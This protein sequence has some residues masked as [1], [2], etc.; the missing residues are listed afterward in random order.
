MLR[1]LHFA[2]LSLSLSCGAVLAAENVPRLDVA[3]T[4]RGAYGA[5]QTDTATGPASANKA[6]NAEARQSTYKS[7]MDSEN[8]ARDSAGKRWARV[9][10]ESRRTCLSM[11][12]AIFPSY[13]ELDA[14][15]QMYDDKDPALSGGTPASNVAPRKR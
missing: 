1:H 3:R 13:V 9:K 6:A 2:A 8:A 15:L 10:G 4:C 14:C 5:L 11:A 7:C 12:S